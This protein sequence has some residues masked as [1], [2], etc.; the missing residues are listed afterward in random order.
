[1]SYAQGVFR[2]RVPQPPTPEAFIHDAFWIFLG[3]APDDAERVAFQS[4]YASGGE[5]RVTE[6]LLASPEFHLIVTFCRD[7]VGIPGDPVSHE[8]GL[9]ALG[10]PDQFV[11]LAYRLL[12]GREADPA[13]LAHYV[14]VLGAGE[15][16]RMV[17]RTFITS[18]EFEARYTPIVSDEGGYI[19]RDVQLCELANPAKWDN[20]DWI[21]LLKSL[22]VPHH[23]LSMHRK[24]YEWT[25][26]LF[27]LGRLG[28]LG[29]TTSVLSVGAGHECVL[30]WLANHVGRVVATDLYE[31]RWQSSAAREGD[32][33][34]V[35]HPEQFAPFPYRKDRLTFLQMDGRSLDFP[36]HEF[37]AVYSLSSIEHFGGF[38]G[39]RASMIEMARVLKPGGILALATEYIVSGPDYEEAF[40]PAVFR[41]LIEVP[42]LELVEP[43]DERVSHRY[44]SPIVDLRVNLHQRPH[45][46]V[47]I[48][49]TVFTSVMV[50]LRKA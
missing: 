6:H 32:A 10:A 11:R 33:S 23:K 44:D 48:G 49:D 29:D 14:A 8:A 46:V 20:P 40:Q 26:L 1:M 45:M 24:S 28:K 47:R 39:A 27:G 3:R 36:D 17:I 16:R 41:R 13:G 43:I 37:D 15:A 5:A 31:G 19:P 35:D 22:L 25:Q 21:R 7:D 2:R 30:Y 42:G 38:D 4:H 18:G 12:F 50:F 34:V 9:R